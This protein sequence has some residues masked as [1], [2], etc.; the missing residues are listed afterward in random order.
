MVIIIL[1]CSLHTFDYAMENPD[2]SF[3][4]LDLCFDTII[5]RETDTYIT[6][7]GS[8][9]GS[10]GPAV[11]V[12]LHKRTSGYTAKLLRFHEQVEVLNRQR[13]FKTLET[14]YRVH[15]EHTEHK[16]MRK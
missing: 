15:T 6:Y 13:L 12:T 16:K 2:S 3:H 5:R 4:N 7:T 9:N 11:I 10:D 1:S 8:S 14:M